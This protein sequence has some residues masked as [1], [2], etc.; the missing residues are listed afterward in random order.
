MDP[1]VA[2]VISDV[3]SELSRADCFGFVSVVDTSGGVVV[4]TR[5]DVIDFVMVKLPEDADVNQ[6][7]GGSD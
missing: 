1:D 5:V 3:L 2:A 4:A 7:V 6:S